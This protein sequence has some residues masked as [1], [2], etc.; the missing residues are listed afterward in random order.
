MNYL[1]YN[2]RLHL[3]PSPQDVHSPP[4][5]PA[6]T[7][8]Q[9]GNGWC[10]NKRNCHIWS[11]RERPLSR[12]PPQR[13]PHTTTHT[14]TTKHKSTTALIN[15]R[16]PKTLLSETL[17]STKLCCFT[18]LQPT[19]LH[20]HTTPAQIWDTTYIPTIHQSI[21]FSLH[22]SFTQNIHTQQCTQSTLHK[23]NAQNKRYKDTL[24]SQ[25]RLLA[26]ATR[27][28]SIPRQSEWETN[29]P[30]GSSLHVN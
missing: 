15:K 24:T 26:I 3:P 4:S 30:T 9:L 2:K 23:P 22:I 5:S 21:P 17:N 14:I 10:H 27:P 16:Y 8:T 19:S 29:M 13:A 25:G 6:T 11:R 1:N 18:T 28:Q 20:N 7:T 12:R